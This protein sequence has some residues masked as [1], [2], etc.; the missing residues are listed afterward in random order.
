M[1][2]LQNLSGMFVIGYFFFFKFIK[3]QISTGLLQ[4][5]SDLVAIF[6]SYVYLYVHQYL[7]FTCI[8]VCKLD[9]IAKSVNPEQ[10]SGFALFALP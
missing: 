10:T 9:G 1:Y 7:C 6:T 8:K 2:Y 5:V 4:V 3:D